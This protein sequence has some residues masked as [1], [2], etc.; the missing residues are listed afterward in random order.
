ME[1]TGVA[2]ARTALR[3]LLLGLITRAPSGHLVLGAPADR[4]PGGHRW[5]GL[6]DLLTEL[7]ESRAGAA[8]LAAVAD[9]E[10]RGLTVTE[11][12]AYHALLRWFQTCV[13][14]GD[15]GELPGWAWRCLERGLTQ[16]RRAAGER[17]LVAGHCWYYW[18]L[19]LVAQLGGPDD[20]FSV[21]SGG[22]RYLRRAPG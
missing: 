2:H 9:R 15:R 8:V 6:A 7:A 19:E 16:E 4:W 20:Q 18:A 12:A 5:P 10:W 13:L 22:W 1:G 17:L 3:C 11:V 14:E 21:A